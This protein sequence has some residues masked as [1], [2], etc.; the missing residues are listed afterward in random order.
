MNAAMEGAWDAARFIIGGEGV[1]FAIQREFAVS[2]AVTVAPDRCAEEWAIVE[3]ALEGIKSEREVGERSIG[4]G[5]FHRNQNGAV[6][7]HASAA[8]EG[9]GESEKRD[10]TPIWKLAVGSFLYRGEAAHHAV[11]W[12]GE[13]IMASVEIWGLDTKHCSK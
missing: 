12:H 7:H 13:W 8:A 2:D 11:F 1:I 5:R 6:V 10:L 9:V 3:P 4:V